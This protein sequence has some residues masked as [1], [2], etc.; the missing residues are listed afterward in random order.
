MNG[1][2]QSVKSVMFSATSKLSRMESEGLLAILD[3][4]SIDFKSMGMNKDK[5]T[6]LFLC[7]KDGL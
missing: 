6:A 2:E 5:K 7:I 4:D 1:A 3:H